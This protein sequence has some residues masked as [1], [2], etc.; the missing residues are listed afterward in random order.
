MFL[1][2]IQTAA[3]G[4]VVLIT[5]S[6]VFP[7]IKRTIR[8]TMRKVSYEMKFLLVRSGERMQDMV[9]EVK[10]ERMKRAMANIDTIECE[11]YED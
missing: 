5:G 2:F 10:F 11:V 3:V 1:R 4:S 9:D 7:V 6:A 8:P